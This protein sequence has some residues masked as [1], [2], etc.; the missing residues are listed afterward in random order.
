MI[1]ERPIKPDQKYLEQ[2]LERISKV[3]KKEF[4]KKQE[5]PVLPCYAQKK[6]QVRHKGVH[7]RTKAEIY[8]EI[9]Q[10]NR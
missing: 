5:Q 10:K 2:Y 7:R 4:L 8:E 6:H 1:D 9:K 3:E